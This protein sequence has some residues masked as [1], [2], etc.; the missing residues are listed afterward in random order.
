MAQ[1]ML[2]ANGQVVPRRSSRPLK[3]DEIHSVTEIKKRE[4]FDGLTQRR[5]GTSINPPKSAESE[6]SDDNEFEEHEDEDEPKRTVP[7]IEDTVD[8]KWQAVKPAAGL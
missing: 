8:A 4:M 5:W 3:V 1:W 6:D 2:K 7:D